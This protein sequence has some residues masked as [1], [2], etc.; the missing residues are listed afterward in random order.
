MVWLLVD[1]GFIRALTPGTILTILLLIVANVM[2]V[3]VSWSYIR[4]R[5]SGQADTN[6]VTLP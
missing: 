1:I 5:L 3:G 4:A 6:N 2:A